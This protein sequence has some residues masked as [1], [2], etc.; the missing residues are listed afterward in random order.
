MKEREH[1]STFV[2][3]TGNPQEGQGKR[4]SEVRSHMAKKHHQ[5][6]IRQ[7][8]VKTRI[9]LQKIDA[10]KLRNALEDLPRE[11]HITLDSPPLPSSPTGYKRMQR[12]EFR[13]DIAANSAKQILR[14]DDNV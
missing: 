8:E 1:A 4:L 3:V 2:V 11:L 10:V 5:H 14:S 12:C 7:N 6:R 9:H 13:I